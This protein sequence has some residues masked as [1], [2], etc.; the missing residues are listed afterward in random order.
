M[1]LT[2]TACGSAIQTSVWVCN[3]LPIYLRLFSSLI[4]CSRRCHK[5]LRAPLGYNI[6]QRTRF[7]RAVFFPFVS[8]VVAQSPYSW[9]SLALRE[10]MTPMLVGASRENDSSSYNEI[11]VTNSA[12]DAGWFAFTHPPQQTFTAQLW[13]WLR[14][15]FC[16][17]MRGEKKDNKRKEHYQAEK[18]GNVLLSQNWCRQ[19]MYVYK[20]LKA[21]CSSFQYAVWLR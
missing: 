9:G 16:E 1:N 21:K 4:L 6:T 14:H 7:A 3:G 20:I 10:L 11:N 12:S 13:P 8:R 18:G 2:I 15:I 5:C 17:R 19:E